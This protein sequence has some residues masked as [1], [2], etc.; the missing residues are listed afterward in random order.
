MHSY[1]YST[2][3]VAEVSA[4]KFAIVNLPSKTKYRVGC[5]GSRKSELIFLDSVLRV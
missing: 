5:K 1:L 2:K 3:R 4:M